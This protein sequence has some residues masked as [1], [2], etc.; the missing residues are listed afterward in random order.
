[1]AGRDRDESGRPRNTRPRDALGRPLPPGSEGF[2][3]IP[4]ELDLTPAAT[5]AYAQELLDQGLAFNAHEVL[6]AAWKNGPDDERV[7]WQGLAQLA[8]GITHVQRGNPKGALAVLRRSSARLADLRVP[9]YGIDAA[10]LAD[11]ADAMI[12]DLVCGA[13]IAEQRLAPR[14]TVQSG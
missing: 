2:P 7:L 14:L 4:D 10:G 1:M 5:L 13:E 9:P 6:E 11:W 12:G 3:R 8:V